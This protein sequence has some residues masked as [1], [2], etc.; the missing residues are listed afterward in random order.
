MEEQLRQ[1]QKMETLGQLAGGVAHDFNNVLAVVMGCLEQILDETIE[2]NEIHLSANTAMQAAQQAAALTSRLLAFSRGQTLTPVELDLGVVICE[3]QKMLRS[4]LPSAIEL[5]LHAPAPARSVVDRIQLE[6]A[7]MN[8]VVNARDAIDG[9]GKIEVGVDRR[10]ITEEEATQELRAGDWIVVYVK[11]SGRGIDRGLQA[12]IFEPFFTTKDVG[13]GTGLGLS[14]IHGF[15]SQSGGFVT[16]ES[17]PGAGTWI[18]LH[19]PATGSA[20]TL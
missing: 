5:T 19:F 7:V 6:T 15:V 3:L 2:G 9:Y 12:R 4:A 14:Q 8:L 18:A 16:V 13:K 10:S 17:T 20:Q 11:D 1:A